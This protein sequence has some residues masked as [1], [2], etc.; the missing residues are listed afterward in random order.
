MEMETCIMRVRVAIPAA[1]PSIGGRLDVVQREITAGEPADIQSS[2]LN[3]RWIPA[4]LTQCMEDTR[5]VATGFELGCSDYRLVH[6]KI[7]N[8]SECL[9][10]RRSS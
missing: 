9:A 7:L 2:G 10:I 3:C 8:E 1:F 6:Q 5:F 4:L